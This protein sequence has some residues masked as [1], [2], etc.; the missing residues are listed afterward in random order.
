MCVLSVI[1]TAAVINHQFTTSETGKGQT[2]ALIHP[3]SLKESAEK[4]IINEMKQLNVNETEKFENILNQN[5]SNS[6]TPTGC[7]LCHITYNKLSLPVNGKMKK[8]AVCK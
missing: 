6:H 8:C 3:S 2:V 4:D 5:H 1:G 7:S